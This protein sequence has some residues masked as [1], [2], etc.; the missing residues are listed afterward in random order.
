MGKDKTADARKTSGG[1]SAIGFLIVLLVLSAMSAAAGVGFACQ[2]GPAPG[3]NAPRDAGSDN[4]EHHAAPPTW[5]VYDLPPVV[6]NLGAPTDVWVRIEASIVFDPREMK[7]PEAVGAMITDDI[8]AYMRTQT[9]DQLQ[10]PVGLQ[11]LRRELADRAFVRSDKQV[12]EF[13]LKTLVMQ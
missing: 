2:F 5:K 11:S 1:S 10:G 13:L 8:L 9:L 3:A 4:D 12:K 6:T 7:T